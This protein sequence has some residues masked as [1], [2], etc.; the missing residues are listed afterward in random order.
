MM[1]IFSI[2]SILVSIEIHY[3]E[4]LS[5]SPPNVKV[6]TI[7]LYSLVQN[8]LIDYNEQCFYKIIINSLRCL[9]L[10]SFYL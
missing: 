1:M 6:F 9:Y 8:D 4:S 7:W 5:R 3:L 2:K 10:S